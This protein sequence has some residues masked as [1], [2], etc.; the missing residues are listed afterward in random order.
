MCILECARTLAGELIPQHGAEGRG[1]L[2]E[3]VPLSPFGPGDGSQLVRLPGYG[4]YSASHRLVP[5]SSFG[6]LI[7]RG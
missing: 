5:G 2:T 3:V 4:L 1:Q 7:F 6:D